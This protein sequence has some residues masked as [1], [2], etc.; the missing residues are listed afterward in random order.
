M[1]SGL[2]EEQ[3]VNLVRDFNN[4]ASGI[5]VLIITYNIGSV[6][7]NLHEACV[8][9]ILSTPGRSW[10]NE[11]QAFGRCLRAS[12]QLAINAR[13]PAIESLLL[14]LLR[15]LQVELDEFRKSDR[16]RD[17]MKEKV[18]IDREYEEELDRFLALKDLQ[19]RVA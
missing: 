19:K 15:K 5:K 4:P 17:L 16:A 13:D 2:N 9:V 12:L 3:R 6:C 11:A 14:K 18:A 10:D 1:H 7:L 8:L